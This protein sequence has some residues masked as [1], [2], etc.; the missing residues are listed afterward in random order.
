MFTRQ[1]YQYGSLQLKSRSKGPD[2]WELRYYELGSRKTVTVGDVEKYPTK[3]SAQK[4]IQGLLLK[5]N[6]DS[7]SAALHVTTFGA[8]VDRFEQDEMPDHHS[9]RVSYKSLLKNH[10]KPKWSDVR[11]DRLKPMA[12]EIW[13]NALPLAPKTRSNIRSLMHSIWGCA[14]RWDLIDLQRNPMEVV[15]VKGGSKRKARPAILTLPEFGTL[16]ELIPEPYKTMVMVA[17]C[18]GLR[19]SEIVG[20]QWDDFDFEE[21]SVLIERGIVHGRIGDAK[22]EYSRDRVPIDSALAEVLTRHREKLGTEASPWVFA[23]P[24]T[25]KPYHQDSIQQT[26]IREAGVKAGLTFSVGWHT[27]RH[28]YRSLLDASGAPMTVQQQLMRHASIQT[29]MNVYGQA[30]PEGKR[31]ANS[32]VVEM[33]LAAPKAAVGEVDSPVSLSA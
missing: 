8:V 13:L 26:Q 14:L 33:V 22:T 6:S 19:A 1:R 3:A 18:L 31:E 32:K 7:P 28:T 24:K 5:V 23:N 27:F 2:V 20:L 10:I 15:R 12:V 30:M 9:T 21:M 4:A 17:M 16:V 29:T 11:L 25:G